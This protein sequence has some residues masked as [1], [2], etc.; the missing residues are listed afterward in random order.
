MSGMA[1]NSLRIC[2]YQLNILFSI[3]SSKKE[4]F[5]MWN[6]WNNSFIVLKLKIFNQTLFV[7]EHISDVN[8]EEFRPSN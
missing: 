2:S 5:S 6:S 7:T 8:E 4:N 1:S 3:C